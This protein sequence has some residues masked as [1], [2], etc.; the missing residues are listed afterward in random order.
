M[1][2]SKALIHGEINVN[3][4]LVRVQRLE[5]FKAWGDK[6]KPDTGEGAEVASVQRY[7]PIINWLELEYVQM[8]FCL[9]GSKH[10]KDSKGR[11]LLRQNTTHE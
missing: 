8:R 2:L 4:T 7:F 5:L 1:E 9:S 10:I 11:F 3:L 6:C